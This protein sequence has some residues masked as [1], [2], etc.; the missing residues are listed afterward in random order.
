MFA[1][2]VASLANRSE[3]GGPMIHQFHLD[4]EG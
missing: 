4:E 1:Q 2:A 3:F